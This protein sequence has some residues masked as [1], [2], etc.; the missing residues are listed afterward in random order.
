MKKFNGYSISEYLSIPLDRNKLVLLIASVITVVEIVDTVISN[1]SGNLGINFSSNPWLALFIIFFIVFIISQYFLL[2]LVRS[3]IKSI[4]IPHWKLIYS[5]V[6]ISQY[7]L[8]GLIIFVI[9]QS[10]FYSFY[11]TELLT[12]SNGLSLSLSAILFG[13]LSLHFFQWYKQIKNYMILLFGLALITLSISEELAAIGMC[14]ALLIEVNQTTAKSDPA[15]PTLDNEPVLAFLADT[16]W[17]FAYPSFILLWISIVL[18]MRR[19]SRKLGVRRY[20]VIMSLPLAYYIPVILGVPGIAPYIYSFDPVLVTIVFAINSTAGAILFAIAFKKLSNTISKK[21]SNVKNYLLISAYGLLF[22]F[23][24]SQAV[25]VHAPYLPFGL[26]TLSLVGL[27]SYY[28]F[29]GIYSSVISIAQDWEV[30][31][32]IKNSLHDE[33]K[34]LSDM[35]AAQVNEEIERKVRIAEQNKGNMEK[36]TGL[37]SSLSHEEIKQYVEEVIKERFNKRNSKENAG[38]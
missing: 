26:I 22:Y 24:S 3:R 6:Y 11:T 31:K 23:V 13:I 17:I 1:I 30:R 10:M 20:W 21:E 8:T 29:V 16:Y 2:K 4:K 5:I 33:A 27:A 14:G 36:I 25:V 34:F 12:V 19:Y 15:F 35:G 37:G 18:L 9:I 32:L 38:T 7:V 28:V